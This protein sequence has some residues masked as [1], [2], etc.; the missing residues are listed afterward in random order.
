MV[1][2]YL[3]LLSQW[4]EAPAS[5]QTTSQITNQATNP[6]ATKPETAKPKEKKSSGWG[7]S[8]RKWRMY[9]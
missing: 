3:T 9:F 2:S 8:F 7:K 1:H 4:G 5:S 6:A